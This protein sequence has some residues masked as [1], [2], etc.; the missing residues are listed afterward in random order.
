MVAIRNLSEETL[1]KQ[2][3]REQKDLGL[4][5]LVKEVQDICKKVGIRDISE[6]D[7]TK[8]EMEDALVTYNLKLTKEEMGDKLKYQEMKNEDI[9]KPQ[10][11]LE[12]MNLEECSIAMR[13]KCFM[14]DCPGNMRA[15]YKGRE[16]CLRCKLKPE[17]QG[18]A[19]RETQGHLEVCSGYSELR[20]GRDLAIFSDKVAYFA[21]V[22][23]EREKMLINI[24]KA[25]EKKVRKEKT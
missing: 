3:F 11:F 8:E 24:R 17:F 4:P 5:G 16:T 10:K 15:R 6:E 2:V 14:M 9:R 12:E 7:V 25:K 20:V 13:V 23:K 21:D 1:A 18:P 19:M 22:I